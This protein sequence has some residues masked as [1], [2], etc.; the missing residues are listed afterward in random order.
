MTFYDELLA[1]T[2]QQRKEFLRIPFLVDGVAGRLQLP[3]YVAFLTQA[4]YHVKQTVPL[5]R[6]CGERLPARLDWL[7][8]AVAAYIDEEQ[9]HD[10]WILND[11]RACGGEAEVVRQGRPNEA[12]EVMIAYAFDTV[13]RL[14]PVGLF[15]M[16]LVL[17]GTSVNLATRAAE[18]LAAALT[19]PREAFSY[20]LSHGSLDQEHIVFFRQ[21]MNRLTEPQD[22]EA[23]V[24]CARV[25]YRLYGDMFRSL[26]HGAV[27]AAA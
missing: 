18:A 7:R 11:I 27:A 19:L 22:Q 26:P 15:G 4:Y 12:T 3:S 17:E 10:E 13:H 16:V 25:V 24:H 2:E 14:N 23:V 1:A 6:M 20:L 8:V 5:F 21:L 9:G